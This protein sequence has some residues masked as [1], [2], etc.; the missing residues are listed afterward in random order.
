MVLTAKTKLEEDVEL[1]AKWLPRFRRGHRDSIEVRRKIVR[2]DGLGTNLLNAFLGA[3]RPR[4][5]RETKTSWG[6]K[7]TRRDR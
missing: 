6:R 5:V 1:K 2:L 3:K 7:C 4:A